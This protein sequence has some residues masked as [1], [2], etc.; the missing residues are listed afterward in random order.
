VARGEHLL[1]GQTIADARTIVLEMMLA[2]NGIAYP[3]E[4]R[5]LNTYLGASQRAAIEKHAAAARSERRELD[6]PGRGAGC[7]LSLVRAA[8]GPPTA[9]TYPQDAETPRWLRCT[10]CPTGR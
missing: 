3:A 6:R 2:L 4:T 7:H 10:T 5:H 1:C 8:T 9:W